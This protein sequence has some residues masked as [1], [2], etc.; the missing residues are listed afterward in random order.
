M[1]EEKI[2]N[3]LIKEWLSK[4]DAPFLDEAISRVEKR[5]DGDLSKHTVNHYK[6]LDKRE[7]FTSIDEMIKLLASLKKEG[8]ESISE[9]WSGYEDN[10]FV[11]DKYELE[12]DREYASR[13][14]SVVSVEIDS[15]K[16]ELEEKDRKKKEI[17]RLED[18]IRKLKKGMYSN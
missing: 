6:W 18:E 10:Y 5:R 11:A 7:L 17:K 2:K 3:L 9:G 14:F 13:V 4:E 15:I 16:D 1:L 8:Y 12:T